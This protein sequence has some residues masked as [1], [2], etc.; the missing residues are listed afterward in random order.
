M[1]L[2]TYLPMFTLGVPT[3]YLHCYTKYTFLKKEL[4][5]INILVLFFSYNYNMFFNFKNIN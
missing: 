1:N 4:G 3:L 2:F 5:I